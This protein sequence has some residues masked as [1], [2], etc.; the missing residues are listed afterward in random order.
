M[1]IKKTEEADLSNKRSLYTLIGLVL[2]L[3][4]G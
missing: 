1:R 3:F 2:A 4:Q